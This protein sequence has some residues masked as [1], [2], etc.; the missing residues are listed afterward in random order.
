MPKSFIV[1]GIVFSFANRS[2]DGIKRTAASLPIVAE[3]TD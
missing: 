1:A 3:L 2:S